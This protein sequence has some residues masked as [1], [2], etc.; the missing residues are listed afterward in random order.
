LETIL[1]NAMLDLVSDNINIA[2]R[3]GI[4]NPQ[5][6][7]IARCSPLTAA[8]SR[9]PATFHN[10]V[11]EAVPSWKTASPSGSLSCVLVVQ[12]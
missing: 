11:T 1:S 2:L 3:I 9:T 8:C 5:D 6:A 10:M 4:G 12:I 7:V